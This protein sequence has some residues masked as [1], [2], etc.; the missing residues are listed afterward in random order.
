MRHF[1]ETHFGFVLIL[2][3]LGGLIIPGMPQLPNE[4]SIVALAMLMFISCYKLRDGGFEHISWRDVAVF[5]VLRYALLPPVMWFIAHALIPEYATA[6]FLLSVLPAAVSSPAFTNIYGGT[7]ASAFAIVLVSQ[8][9]TPF[10]IPFQFALIGNAQVTPSVAQLFITLVW[11]I[12]VPMALYQLARKHKASAA[13][14]YAQNKFLSILLI[15]FVIALAVAKQREVILANPVGLIAPLAIALACYAVYIM[16]GY[17]LPHRGRAGVG[18]LFGRSPVSCPPPNPPPTGGG[19]RKERITYATC[20]GFNNAALGVS[21]AL[22]HFPP[23]VILFVAA[24]EIG[25]SLLPVMMRVI[26]ARPSAERG[27]RATRR[28]PHAR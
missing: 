2:S 25:W 18:A 9:A 12:L 4:S 14:F 7:V 22:M 26:L 19:I 16:F 24:S 13:F 3:C 8:L 28:D 17:S 6:V 20:S 11:C 21:L 23:P 27:S 1:I 15:M 5:Y 10:M